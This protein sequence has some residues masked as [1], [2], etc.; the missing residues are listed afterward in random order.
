LNKELEVFNTEIIAVYMTL[1]QLIDTFTLKPV[2]YTEIGSISHIWVFSD[3]SSALQSISNCNYRYAY[4]I[5]QLANQLSLQNIQLHLAWIPSHTGI[6]GNE[7]ADLA[8]K[9]A[10]NQSN[11]QTYQFPAS[12]SFLKKQVKLMCLEK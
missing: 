11:N 7:M 5:H 10:A 8:A 4:K 3:S 6:Y 9:R 2:K 12:Y 1:K